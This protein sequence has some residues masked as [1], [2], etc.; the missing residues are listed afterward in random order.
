MIVV[1]GQ[2]H[3]HYQSQQAAPFA[4]QVTASA[5]AKGPPADY[6]LPSKRIS[7]VFQS[8]RPRKK[9]GFF[10]V[11]LYECHI[12]LLSKL[13]NLGIPR[14][15]RALVSMAISFLLIWYFICVQHADIRIGETM[16]LILTG[17]MAGYGICSLLSSSSQFWAALGERFIYL[18]SFFQ[19]LLVRIAGMLTTLSMRI[20]RISI[21]LVLALA[22]GISPIDIIPDFIPVI[23]WMD[24]VAVFLLLFY[25]ALFMGR[26]A[27]RP[28]F[29]ERIR[30]IKESA[31]IKTKFP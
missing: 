29:R 27:I 2:G 24:D 26:F 15:V 9:T 5:L 4:G 1:N 11:G 22:Y 21:A 17:F 28:I 20:F 12:I 31:R 3:G 25:W 18:F 30:K 14:P 8:R 13:Y 7:L 10:P 23:G 16:G 6:P 19:I